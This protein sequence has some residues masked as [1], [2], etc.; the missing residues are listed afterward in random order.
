[1]SIQ[2]RNPENTNYLQPTKFQVFF[3]KITTVTYFCKEVN[4]P[5]LHA[6]N[7]TQATPFKDLPRPGD[8]LQY[9]DFSIEFII[10]EELWAWQV[11]HDWLRGYTFPCSFD[12]YRNMNRDS[13]ISMRSLQPQYCD[14]ELQILSSLNNPKVKIKFLNLFP[15]SLSEVKFN[16]QQSA[17]TIL[18]A[19]A[20]FKYHLFNIAR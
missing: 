3:P 11:L 14:A 17:D 7:P 9:G 13:I 16:T 20:T 5:G 15:V 8:K 4:V 2:N 12:E 19:V 10:D 1:M 18:T 6:N